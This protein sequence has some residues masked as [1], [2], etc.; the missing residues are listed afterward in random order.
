MNPYF[1]LVTDHT[2]PEPRAPPIVI[3]T[4]NPLSLY[5]RVRTSPAVRLIVPARFTALLPRI[6][7]RVSTSGT[8]TSNTG[9]YAC[10][11]LA[12]DGLILVISKNGLTPAPMLVLVE[13]TVL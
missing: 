4:V 1:I 9:K 11:R 12:D 7:L 8:F 2:T 6:V 13:E 5:A 3:G 10:S